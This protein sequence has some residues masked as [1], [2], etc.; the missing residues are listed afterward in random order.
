MVVQEI[1]LLVTKYGVKNVKI[2]DE[3]FV[4]DESHYM[5]IVDLLIA[6]GYDLNIWVYA[7]VDTVKPENLLKMKMAGINWLALGIE[8]ANPDVRDGAS[9]R[10]RVKDITNVVRSIQDAGIRL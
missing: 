6:K 3:L 1:G 10:M 9:K 7:R 8:S 2:V 5:R 4:L